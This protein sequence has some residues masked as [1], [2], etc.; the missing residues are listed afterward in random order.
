MYQN[1][2]LNTA[3]QKEKK[4]TTMNLRKKLLDKKKKIIKFGKKNWIAV[5]VTNVQG[6]RYYAKT[7]YT[8]NILLSLKR[9]NKCLATHRLLF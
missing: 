1:R 3:F 7:K 4:E 8:A 5:L 9:S 6:N 2:H